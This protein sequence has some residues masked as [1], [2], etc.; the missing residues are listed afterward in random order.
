MEY[1][2]ASFGKMK[3]L[4]KKVKTLGLIL[5]TEGVKNQVPL[6]LIKSLPE[7]EPIHLKN[8][9]LLFHMNRCFCFK[10]LNG[11]DTSMSVKATSCVLCICA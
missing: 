4:D 3:N 2:T 1:L 10:Q 9:K 5:K 6:I 11:L 7:K 8:L